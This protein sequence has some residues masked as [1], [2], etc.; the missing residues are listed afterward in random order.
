MADGEILEGNFPQFWQRQEEVEKTL[1]GGALSEKRG[2]EFFPG[3]LVYSYSARR[4]RRGHKGEKVVIERYRGRRV[5]HLVG[6]R[7]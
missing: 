5:W 7:G 6:P 4:K 2:R 3:K 1:N